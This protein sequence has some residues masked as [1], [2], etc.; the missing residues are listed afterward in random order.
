MLA[1]L[2]AKPML[3]GKLS[4]VALAVGVFTCTCACAPK[5]RQ[6]LALTHTK[7]ATMGLEKKILRMLEV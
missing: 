2:K 5:Q 3:G 6:R 1:C 7:M 4:L